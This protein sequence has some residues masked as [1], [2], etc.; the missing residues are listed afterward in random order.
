MQST[1]KAM[2]NPTNTSEH[3][4]QQASHALPT[5]KSVFMK[6]QAKAAESMLAILHHRLK[7]MTWA[8]MPAAQRGLSASWT[9]ILHS[10]SLLLTLCFSHS[11][12]H[13]QASC[14][15]SLP[16]VWPPILHLVL[17]PVTC[18]GMPAPRRRLQE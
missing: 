2:T 8:N 18:A 7:P 17:E 12:R 11:D 15:P 1:L 14:M 5:Q 6:V 4:F 9:A 13:H 16:V 10:C 3:A